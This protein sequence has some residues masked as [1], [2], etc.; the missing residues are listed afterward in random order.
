MA[1]LWK[2]R[3]PGY[4]REFSV[5]LVLLKGFSEEVE[6]DLCT[7]GTKLI[8]GR[9]H[10]IAEPLAKRCINSGG[11]VSYPFDFAR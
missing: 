10:H 7:L 2:K 4:V 5:I 8:R 6:I 11:L 1:M 9:R 3:T